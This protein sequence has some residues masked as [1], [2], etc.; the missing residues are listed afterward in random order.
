[1][2]GDYIK[3]IRLAAVKHPELFTAG[4]Q[5]VCVQHDDWCNQL[6]GGTCNCVPDIT[7]TTMAGKFGVNR[8]GVCRKLG[9]AAELIPTIM[10]PRKSGLN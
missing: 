4:N 2:S 7:L 5:D 3:R 8:K 6:S 9:P 1:M 10:D